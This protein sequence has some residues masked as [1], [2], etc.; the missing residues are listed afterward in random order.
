MAKIKDNGSRLTEEDKSIL[1]QEVQKASE[2]EIPELSPEKLKEMT[3]KDRQ[4]RLDGFLQSYQTI[5][6][7]FRYQF[8]GHFQVLGQQAAAS[9]TPVEMKE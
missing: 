1:A 3:D 5:C 6:Q 9:I 8:V 7:K 2:I 4:N